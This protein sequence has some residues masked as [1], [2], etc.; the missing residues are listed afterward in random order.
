RLLAMPTGG[1]RVARRTGPAGELTVPP[2]ACS[3]SPAS[4]RSAP[5][6]SSCPGPVSG[7]AATPTPLS[8][9][10]T[11]SKPTA[12]RVVRHRLNRGGVCPRTREYVTRRCAQ[13]KSDPLHG[14]RVATRGDALL[15]P[16][17]TRRL[18][19]E[20]LSRPS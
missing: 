7:A 6:R 13:G 9:V 20:Y 18:I 8:L 15:S 1:R 2:C 14:I 17:I 5:P 19:S 3:A 10:S 4:D 12:G 16:A 11:R